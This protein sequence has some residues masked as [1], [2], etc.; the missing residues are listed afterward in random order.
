MMVNFDLL[1][2]LSDWTHFIFAIFMHRKS[3]NR[4]ALVRPQLC[5]P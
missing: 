5:M 1:S 2:F 4:N 3:F